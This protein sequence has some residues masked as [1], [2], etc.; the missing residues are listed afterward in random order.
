[1]ILHGVVV[2]YNPNEY[3]LENIKTYIDQ[4][5]ILYLIDIKFHF[6]T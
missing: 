2:L 3:I 4:I 1:M 6:F 5:E